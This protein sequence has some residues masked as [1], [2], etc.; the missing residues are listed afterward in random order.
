MSSSASS[1]SSSSSVVSSSRGSRP[2]TVRSAPHSS[3]VSVSP[4]SSSSSSTSIT[5]SQLGQLTISHPSR[6]QMFPHKEFE[7]TA[8]TS[9]P[10]PGGGAWWP[11]QGPSNED[12]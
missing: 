3:Q 9:S 8:S 11:E 10:S 12:T 4:S 1:S 5:A 2:V 7:T 6:V